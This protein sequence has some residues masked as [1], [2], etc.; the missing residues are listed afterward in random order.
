[1][2]RLSAASD[3][4][5]AV[6]S[7]SVGGRFTVAR[8]MVVVT[9]ALSG[10]ATTIFLATVNRPPTD[11]ERTAVTASLAADNR[12]IVFADLFWA[13]LNAKEFAFNH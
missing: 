13:L 12:E 11:A 3:E 2:S 10:V 6:R 1:M 5:T 9:A 8:K 7:A 4:V